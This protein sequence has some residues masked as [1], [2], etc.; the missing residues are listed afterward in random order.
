MRR[1]RTT[2][3][4]AGCDFSFQPSLGKARIMALAELNFVD[5]CE[6]VHRFGPPG[7]GKSVYFLPRADLIGELA[8]PERE[9]TLRERIR[10]YCPPALLIVHEIGYLPV[11]P[12]GGNLY[13]R[14]VKTRYE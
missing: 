13:F 7:T 2:K 5:R 11:V 4:L 14:L 12:G 9:G 6:V 10:F 1:L 3:A 8:K